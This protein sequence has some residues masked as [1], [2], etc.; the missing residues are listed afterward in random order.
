MVHKPLIRPA[1]SGGGTL[2][3]GRLTSHEVTH[4]PGG[5]WGVVPSIQR[6]LSGSTLGTD[7]DKWSDM[8]A[9]F[10][11]AGNKWVNGVKSRNISGMFGIFWALP[12]DCNSGSWGFGR[13]HFIKMNR[14][15]TR[16]VVEPTH[17]KNMLVKLD[18]FPNFRD[19]NKQC[20]KPPLLLLMAEIL[21]HLGCMKPYK[22][23]EKLP[24]NWPYK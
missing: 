2:G 10:W 19:E 8:G 12:E 17:L 9:P 4:G 7:L 16:L 18:H 21:H 5:T 15:F 1:I 13:V 3:G 6:P 23:W 22:E 20:L 11:M 14:L 24:I